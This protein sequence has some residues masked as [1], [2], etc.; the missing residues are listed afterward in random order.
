[1]PKKNTKEYDEVV[2]I[3]PR[4]SA[5][6]R[7]SV[8]SILRKLDSDLVK[9]EARETRRS[10]SRWTPTLYRVL[11]S[12]VEFAT[13]RRTLPRDL[14][15]MD[16]NV[17][18]QIDKLATHLEAQLHA[19]AEGEGLKVTKTDRLR[20]Y[21]LYSRLV[22]GYLVDCRVPVTIKTLCQNSDKFGGL[23]DKEFPDYLINAMLIRM[24]LR[25]DAP[26][27]PGK[28]HR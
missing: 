22:G 12:R 9:E 26:G 24:V 8:F 4:L 20:W 27:A 1:M 23:I 14:N 5:Q 21:R 17:I 25:L 3:L 7:R 2:S 19:I 6:E 16:P 18:A 28:E 11:V 10:V 13:R 15:F